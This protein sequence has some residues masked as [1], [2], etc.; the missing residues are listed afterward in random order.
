[1]NVLIVEDQWIIAKAMQTALENYGYNSSIVANGSEA[2]SHIC[3]EKTDI[4]LMDLNLNSG[5]S[6][7]DTALE[8][9]LYSDVPVIFITGYSDDETVMRA[10]TANPY[11]FIVKPVNYDDLRIMIEIAVYKHHSDKKILEIEREKLIQE[12]INQRNQRL[13]S[14]GELSASI[15]HEIKQPLQVIK[16][17]TDSILSDHNVEKNENDISIDHIRKIAENAEKIN[18]IISKLSALFKKEDRV[19]MQT[20]DLNALLKQ[21]TSFF[22]SLLKNRSIE[23]E[24]LLSDNLPMFTYC[25][26]QFEQ[27]ITNLIK[28]SIDAFGESSNKNRKVIIKTS[29][30]HSHILLEFI[31]TATGIK[32]D[33]MEKILNPLFTTKTNSESMGLGLYIVNSIVNAN[34]GFIDYYNNELGGTTFNILFIVR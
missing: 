33:I 19:N 6:G 29:K 30:K 21:T 24:L 28:N 8:M 5:V 26:V 10:K 14:L 25:E 23:I 27:I 31:D 2:I 4:V 32:P 12:K 16:M 7:I 22:N 9:K 20:L 34:N 11:G 18:S 3:S 1:M 15:T 13:T 17:L